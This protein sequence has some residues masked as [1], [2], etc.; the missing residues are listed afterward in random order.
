MAATPFLAIFSSAALVT[1]VIVVCELFFSL[2]V[3][4]VTVPSASLPHLL[5]PFS[6][7]LVMN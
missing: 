4:P 7:C 2:S 3:Q 6:G 5:H 1:Q